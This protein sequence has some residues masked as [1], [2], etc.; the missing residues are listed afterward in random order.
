MSIRILQ[1][2]MLICSCGTG[3]LGMDNMSKLAKSKMVDGVSCNDKAE[4]K[5]VC[6]PC[7]MEK[8]HRISYPKGVST[9][10]VEAFDVVQ[11]DFFGHK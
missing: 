4:R 10:A 6:E 7:I 9:C 3:H 11:S 1:E 2:K 5:F 8:Q